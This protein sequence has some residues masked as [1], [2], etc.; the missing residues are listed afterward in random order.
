MIGEFSTTKILQERFL[1]NLPT[2]RKVLSQFST[3]NM[4]FSSFKNYERKQYEKTRNVILRFCLPDA[5]GMSNA[6][7]LAEVEDAL[8]IFNVAKWNRAD[9]LEFAGRLC[10]DDYTTSL[11]AYTELACSKWLAERLGKKKVEIHPELQTGKKSDILVKLDAKGAYLEVG[12]LA[13]SL[14]ERKIKRILDAGAKYLGSKL[15]DGVALLV[16]IDTTEL[17]VQDSNERIDEEKSVKKLNSEI[18]RLGIDR[19][20]GYEGTIDLDELASALSTKELW[21]PLLKKMPAFVFSNERNA[22]DLMEAPATAR[23]IDS[24][25]DEIA[26]GSKLIKSI[27]R[28]SFKFLLVEIHEEMV[29]PSPAALSERDSFIR[30][31][32]RHVKSQIGQLQP[33][34]PNIIVVQGFNWLIFG[35]GED[36][37]NIGSLCLKVR[38]FLDIE[39][40]ENLS[41]IAIFERDFAKTTFIPNEHAKEASKLTSDEIEK[42]GMHMVR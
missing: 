6:E 17:L 18:D 24:C 21:K 42:I 2:A 25:G 20:A 28:Y 22:L 30:H 13:P 35:L 4:F 14:P 12:N 29:Y 3:L 1:E 8:L 41:G 37:E 33:N 15:R 31:F 5:Q 26:K 36:L 38:E 32:I 34:S 40:Q 7:S 23:W 10:S 27:S 11:S 9:K 19:V 39:R 16:N